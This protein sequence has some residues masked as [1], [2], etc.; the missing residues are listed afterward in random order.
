MTGLML[1]SVS[2]VR[3]PVLTWKFPDKGRLFTMAGEPVGRLIPR[4]PMT[5]TKES[6]RWGWGPLAYLYQCR[7]ELQDDAGACAGALIGPYD[8]S[9][10]HAWVVD[11]AGKEMASLAADLSSPSKWLHKVQPLRFVLFK[12]GT[13]VGSMDPQ[14]KRGFAI[15]A[16]VEALSIQKDWLRE[17][18]TIWQ[19]YT[20]C[21]T[22]ALT[23]HLGDTFTWFGI[24]AAICSHR[25]PAY[26]SSPG[27]A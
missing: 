15:G 12:D 4:H 9:A 14:M 5:P 1:S 10:P 13:A 6:L 8:R 19:R 27:G 26:R 7:Y 17:R 2:S 22:R 21:R 11:A 20:I 24:A 16:T 25:E 3:W 18:F 23:V